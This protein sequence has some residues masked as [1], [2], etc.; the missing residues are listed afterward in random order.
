MLP[1]TQQVPELGKRPASHI[2]TG[3]LRE[4]DELVEFYLSEGVELS[5]FNHRCLL[6]KHGVVR[7]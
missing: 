2:L 4:D 5:R 1:D 7:V 3:R 6:L